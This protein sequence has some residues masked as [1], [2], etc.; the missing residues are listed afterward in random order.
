MAGGLYGLFGIVL[1]WRQVPVVR[2]R[3][4]ASHKVL[5]RA[6]ASHSVCLDCGDSDLPVPIRTGLAEVGRV[7]NT[8]SFVVDYATSSNLAFTLPAGAYVRAVHIVK[9]EDFGSQFV[10]LVVGTLA[11]PDGL[12]ADGDHQLAVQNAPSVLVLW[13]YYLADADTAFYVGAVQPGNARGKAVFVVEYV[14]VEDE[15]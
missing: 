7:I 6:I 8:T 11:D 10:S 13:P 15:T 12:I 3:A 2:G 5:Y 1:R 4:C 14:F 9:L